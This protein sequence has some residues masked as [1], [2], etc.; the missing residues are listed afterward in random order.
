LSRVVLTPRIVISARYWAG[1]ELGGRQGR[2]PEPRLACDPDDSFFATLV[3][4]ERLDPALVLV[5]RATVRKELRLSAVR[6][7]ECGA[8][9]VSFVLGG[10]LEARLVKRIEHGLQSRPLFGSKQLLGAFP[11]ET[12]SASNANHHRVMIVKGLQKKLEKP[13]RIRR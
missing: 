8:V 4:A 2:V 13:R 9:L 6:S 11:Q 7:E 3:D 5:P 10:I 1:R 12:Y